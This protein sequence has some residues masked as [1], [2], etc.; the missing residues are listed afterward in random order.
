MRTRNAF[1]LIE[2]LVVI[3]IIALLIALLL[4]AVKR[5]REQARLIACASNLRQI[6]IAGRSYVEDFGGWLPPRHQSPGY[7]LAHL[8]DYNLNFL[9]PPRWTSAGLLYD[10]GHLREPSVS[11]CPS[12]PGQMTWSDGGL[13]YPTAEL[14]SATGIMVSNRAAVPIQINTVY[15]IR[16]S[17]DY[18]TQG[19]LTGDP[20]EPLD[21]DDFGTLYMIGDTCRMLQPQVHEQGFNVA[22]VDG[23]HRFHRGKVADFLDYW[24]PFHQRW[25]TSPGSAWGG[26]DPFNFIMYADDHPAE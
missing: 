3:S 21:V 6:G 22:Y 11:F 10:G 23:H 25:G 8:W 17:R 24:S 5:A 16:S 18:D 1:T 13:W 7:Y 20:G 19:D 14:V 4:P 15:M 12:M 26:D 2:L 9:S